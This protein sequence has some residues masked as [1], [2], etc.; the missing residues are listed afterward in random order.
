M[1]SN[2]IPE[3]NNN[4][5]FDKHEVHYKTTDDR[6]AFTNRIIDDNTIEVRTPHI[7]KVDG[8]LYDDKLHIIPSTCNSIIITKPIYE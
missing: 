1:T 8:V 6:N 3:I 4:N 2:L 7:T 5:G